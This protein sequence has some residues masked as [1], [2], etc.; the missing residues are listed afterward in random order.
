VRGEEGLS[1]LAPPRSEGGGGSKLVEKVEKE[2]EKAESEGVLTDNPLSLS[3]LNSEGRG[4]S[5]GGG[6]GLNFERRE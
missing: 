1:T 4:K 3:I 5:L 6:E 2:E